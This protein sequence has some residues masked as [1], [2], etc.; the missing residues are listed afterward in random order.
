MQEFCL[1]SS[2]QKGT[3]PNTVTELEQWQIFQA[4]K[5]LIIIQ[6]SMNAEVLITILIHKPERVMQGFNKYAEDPF[7]VLNIHNSLLYHLFFL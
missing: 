4:K 1:R 5:P 6:T 3:I 2:Q 7:M